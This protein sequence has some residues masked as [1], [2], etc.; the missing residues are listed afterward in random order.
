MNHSST[1]PNTGTTPATKLPSAATL[2]IASTV[3][4]DATVFG[5]LNSSEA[6]SV[7]KNELIT[8]F[9]QRAPKVAGDKWIQRR[10]PFSTYMEVLTKHPVSKKKEGSAFFFNETGLTG[11]SV[12]ENG[13]K[14][15]YMYRSKAKALSVT[16]FVIDIDGTDS[17]DRVRDQLIEMGLF[18][19]LYTTH[20]HARKASPDGD[21][22]RV[23]IPLERPFTVSEFGGSVRQASAEWLARYAGF[24]KALGIEDLDLSAAKFVQMMYL[25][26][27]ATKDAE[28]K[29]YVV[30]GRALSIEEMPVDPDVKLTSRTPNHA[31]TTERTVS[32][33][34]T[35]AVL[36]DGFD[37]REWFSDCGASFDLELFLECVGWDI[38][39]AAAGDGMTIMC[40]NHVEHSDP[41][42]GS[43]MGCWCCPTDG[44][45]PFLIYCHHDHC[46][47]LNTWDFIC[48]IEERIEDG[49]AALPDEYN[50]LSEMLCDDLFYP[51]IDGQTICVHPTDYGATPKIDIT[52]LGSPKKVEDAFRSVKSNDHAGDADFA[53][54]FA[55]VAKAG[56]KSA[57][58]KRLEKLF[59]ED[60]RFN[61]NDVSRLTS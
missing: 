19:V 54:L 8:G 58:L 43:D 41:D 2:P 36:S 57:A 10:F 45:K 37:A 35:P 56:N 33:T 9:S 52:F 7:L 55:G 6:Q 30:A 27:R 28:F 11:R 12:T 31:G 29:H 40:P 50:S 38:R 25:P 3:I 47:E 26:R 24:A 5:D 32:G 39:D 46:R 15:L 51:E 23:V 60:G 16:A 20:S 53:A 44:E 4:N 61:K 34:S 1:T 49:D 48:K 18:G 21:Y 14:Q 13:D 42:D 59:S 17:I 22:F